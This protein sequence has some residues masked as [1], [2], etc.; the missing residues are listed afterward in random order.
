MTGTIKSKRESFGFIARDG[1]AKDLFF[2]KSDCAGDLFA[3]LAEGTVVEFEI[4][5]T[6]KGPAAKNVRLAVAGEVDTEPKVVKEVEP[7]AEVEA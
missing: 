4:V 7:A 3:S 6:E 5:D 1:E 2:H